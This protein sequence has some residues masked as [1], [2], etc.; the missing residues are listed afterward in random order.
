[1]KRNALI[2]MFITA[3][4]VS[5]V[6]AAEWK[7]QE[8]G[9]PINAVNYENTGGVLA[10]G[11]GGEGTMF[12]SSY[13]RSTGAELVGYDWRTDR[14]TRKKVA[15]C[16]GYGLC[17][18]PDGAV[19]LGGVNPGDL[20]R[21]DPKTDALTTLASQQ[22]G[23]QYIWD[24]A[25]APDGTIYAAAGYPK[26]K[27]VAFKP[28]TSEG[29]DLGEMVPGQQYHR[30]I[31]VDAYGKVWCGIGMKAHLVVYDPANG[32]KQ[33]V[34]PT[35]YAESSSV[36]DMEAVGKYVVA[37]VNFDGVI[38]VYDAKTLEL[39]RTIDRPK[40]QKAYMLAKGGHDDTIYLS[41]L[42]NLDVF[43]CNLATGEV[44]LLVEAF[45]QVKVVE[46]D[47]WVHAID[48]QSY[49]GYDLQEKKEFARKVLT[50]GGDGMDVFALTN[51]PDGNIYGSTY[52]NMHMF[53]CDAD[54]GKLTDLGKV[55]RWAGQVDSLS[56]G[57]DGLIYI[58]AY[59]DAVVSVYDPKRP[60]RFGVDDQANPREIG[61]VG[62]GQYRTRTNCLGPDGKL[63]VGSIP[64]YRSAATG[65]FTVCDPKTGKMDVRT[66][67]VKGGTVEVLV[68]DDKLVYGAGGGEF[69]VLDPTRGEIFRTAR[70]AV[71]MAAL[72]GGKVVGTGK[73]KLFIYDREANAIVSDEANPLGDFTHMA[74]G[75]DGNAYGVNANKVARL[76]GDGNLEILVDKG[77]KYAAVDGK[78][79]VYFARG[80]KLFRCEPQD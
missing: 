76:T 41:T 54:T 25:A 55:S 73:G 36:Y 51:G 32:S 22:L 78:G 27:L 52:I 18:G 20:Y 53:R 13:Y 31:C 74:T 47:R 10:A 70:A 15:S 68:S 30:S 14:L 5:P 44:T 35:R 38:L 69:F 37:S 16:G 62:K 7:V 43:R 71:S 17:V 80:P 12:Y 48:D 1:M 2:A 33:S 57:R 28:G 56:L 9:V 11:P 8:L 49:V 66:D 29:Q 39:V 59:T 58:G 24:A 64:S 72:P 65:A 23:V 45:G 50:A 42:P 63:Y 60:W 21:Y 19:Y 6:A 79:R 3:V 34:L 40:D 46:A 67:F 75:P 77:G 4:L 61:P 26:T